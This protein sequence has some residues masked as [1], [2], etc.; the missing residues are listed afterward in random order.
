M[1]NSKAKSIIIV[2]LALV[3]ILLGTCEVRHQFNGDNPVPTIDTISNGLY[4]QE[5]QKQIAAYEEKIGKLQ[6]QKDSLWFLVAVKKTQ[7]FSERPKVKEYQQEL[8]KQLSEPDSVFVDRDSLRTIADSLIVNQNKEDT[9]CVETINILEQV[10]ANRDSCISVQKLV[11]S[12]LKDI[13]KEQDLK[14]AY[15]TDQ[16][17]TAL[18]MQ[19]KKTRQNKILAGGILLLSGIMTAILM[20]HY[21]K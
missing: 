3:V 2:V 8:Q 13:Q 16:L 18:K 17:N 11:E 6:Q 12:S 1:E 21:L 5:K 9:A 20:P 15:L 19:R 4:R 10:V 7:V 14:A